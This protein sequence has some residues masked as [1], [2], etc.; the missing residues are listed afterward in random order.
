MRGALTNQPNPYAFHFGTGEARV[1]TRR[2]ELLTVFTED[3]FTGNLVSVHDKP[4]ELAPFP[5]INPLTGPIAVEGVR[6]GDII[7]V[8]LV[9]LEP[10]RA[11]VFQQYPQILVLSPA[12]ET[13]PIY[14]QNRQ[15]KYGSGRWILWQALFPQQQEPA[16]LSKRH[17]AIL[18]FAE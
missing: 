9:S 14:N 1:R 11:G 12:R 4:R 17:A 7:A 10:A 6:T 16:T 5:W 2:G 8:H 18:W 13:I 3:C 15:R